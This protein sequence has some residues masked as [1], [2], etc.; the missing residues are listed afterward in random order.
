MQTHP[1]QLGTHQIQWNPYIA[2]T[3]GTVLFGRYSEVSS[4]EGLK[5]AVA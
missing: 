4:I 2:D 5:I 3:I 1:S